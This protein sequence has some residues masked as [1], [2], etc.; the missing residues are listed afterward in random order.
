MTST[1]SPRKLGHSQHWSLS[2]LIPKSPTAENQLKEVPLRPLE[3]QALTHWHCVPVHFVLIF[4]PSSIILS[5][6][7][8]CFL[9]FSLSW[10]GPS[11][12][13]LPRM[14]LAP[15]PMVLLSC[16]VISAL[17]GEGIQ[18]AHCLPLFWTSLKFCFEIFVLDDIPKSLWKRLS[19]VSFEV[20]FSCTA[21]HHLGMILVF[22]AKKMVDSSSGL[23]DYMTLFLTE[24][25]TFLPSVFFQFLPPC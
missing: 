22:G 21:L 23:Y 24:W 2:L 14:C 1:K 11:L 6:S 19:E 20:Q 8:S 7:C 3:V 25:S 13:L 16:P 10:P 5:L 18:M 4:S 17:P 9:T 12:G 15:P